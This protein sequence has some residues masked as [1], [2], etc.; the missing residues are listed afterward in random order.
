MIILLTLSNP[1]KDKLTLGVVG[2]T[3]TGVIEG[4]DNGEGKGTSETTGG[5]VGRHLS[6]V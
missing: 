6:G 3:S 4:V 2:E 5:D 1:V